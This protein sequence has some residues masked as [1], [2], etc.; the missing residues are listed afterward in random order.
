MERFRGVVMKSEEVPTLSRRRFVATA[1]LSCAAAVI[2]PR[3]LLAQYGN[4]VD[5]MRKAAAAAKIDVKPLRRNIYVLTGSGGNIAVLTGK[6]G[7]LL[8]DSGFAVSRT[9]IASALAGISPDPSKHLINT[10]WHVDHTDGNEWLHAAGAEI[11]AQKKTLEHLSTTIRIPLWETTFPPVP[12]GARPTTVFDE[13]RTM[14]LNGTTIALK[15]YLPAHT[16]SDISVNFT[17]ADIVHVGDTWW[18]GYYPFIDYTT[19]GSIDGAIRAAEAN[20][21]NITDNM[22]VIPGH[23]EVG[24][25]AQLIEFREMLITIR[26]K[27]AALKKK[28]NS[29]KETIAAKPTA[30]FDALWGGGLMSPAEFTQL[31]YSGV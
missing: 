6:D 9:A 13:E 2:A 29:L 11:L 14:H 4:T 27:I 17:D 22:I 16:D 30:A 25:R 20:I 3:Q 26:G 19:G 7:K 15:H 5:V 21:A 8:I 10:H 12:A 1:A 28:G 31:V 23:G 18:H 24:G